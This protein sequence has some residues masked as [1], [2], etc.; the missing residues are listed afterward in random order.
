MTRLASC[1]VRKNRHAD[2]SDTAGV[3]GGAGDDSVVAFELGTAKVE[4]EGSHPASRR[5]LELAGGLVGRAAACCVFVRAHGVMRADFAVVLLLLDADLGEDVVDFA[6]VGLFDILAVATR[7]AGHDARAKNDINEPSHQN[8][9]RL[10][11]PGALAPDE[12]TLG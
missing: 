6:D 7:D 10:S 2:G 3:V 12:H 5:V 4:P 9:V 1:F 8:A 11:G